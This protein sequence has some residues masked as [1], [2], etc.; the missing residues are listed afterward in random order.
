VNCTNCSQPVR[1]VVCFDIDGTLGLYH[2]HFLRFANTYLGYSSLD[3]VRPY[4]GDMPFREWFQAAFRVDTRTFRDIKLAYR[5]GA[6]KRSMPVQSWARTATQV[7]RDAGAEVWIT[8]TRPYMRLDNVDP[9]TLFWLKRHGIKFDY[10][11]Y[12]EHKYE[13][14]SRQVEPERVCFVV[15][16]LAEQLRLAVRVFEP[17]ACFMWYSEW[18]KARHDE[19]D[20][21][22]DAEAIYIVLKERIQEW[23]MQH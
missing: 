13:D 11:I 4:D 18:N 5:Q 22:K 20:G 9:D 14:L 12:G 17:D 8:T 7:A 2:E 15:D 3:F 23:K 10:L 21:F 6:Q 19:W 1:P 16:D